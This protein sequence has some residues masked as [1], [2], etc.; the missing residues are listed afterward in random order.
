MQLNKD[1]PVEVKQRARDLLETNYINMQRPTKPTI[2]NTMTLT[3]TSNK[4]FYCK[5]RKLSY[6]EK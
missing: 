5:P 3:L 6:H 2:E 4:P 1:L